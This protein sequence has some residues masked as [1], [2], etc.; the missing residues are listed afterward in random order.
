MAIKVKGGRG[1]ESL[2]VYLPAMLKGGLVVKP[3]GTE[4]KK[5]IGALENDS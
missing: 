4:N 5:K 1:R 2:E 3:K